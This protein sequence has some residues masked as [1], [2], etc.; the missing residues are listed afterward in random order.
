MMKLELREVTYGN[1][2]RRLNQVCAG[3]GLHEGNDKANSN[4]GQEV[5]FWQKNGCFWAR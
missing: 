3:G 4:W 1:C 5:I 2:V